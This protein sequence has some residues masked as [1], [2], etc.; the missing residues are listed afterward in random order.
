MII[1]SLDPGYDRLGIA[2]IEK[3]VRGKEKLLFSVCH[4]TDKKSSFEDRLLSITHA[5]KEVITR[6][7]PEVCVIEKLFFQKNRKTAMLVSRAIGALMITALDANIPIF[8]YTPLEIKKAVTGNGGSTKIE[9]MKMIPMLIHC[10]KLSAGEDMF[11]D[12][13]DAIAVGLTHCAMQRS[14]LLQR[15]EFFHSP[16]Y[17]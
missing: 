12:E 6:Y 8:E 14:V 10:P 3:N 1:V 2:V 11:D 9:M 17:P 4:V 13:F 15:K 7:S 5:L 16:P